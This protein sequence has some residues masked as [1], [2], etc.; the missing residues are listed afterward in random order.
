MANEIKCPYCSAPMIRGVIH[1]TGLYGIKWI[2]ADKDK[3][4]LLSPLAKGI[5]LTNYLSSTQT[6]AL[7]CPGCSKI[8]IDLNETGAG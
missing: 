7:Y 4:C 2:P 3:G 8:I 6:E 1:Q 5:Y